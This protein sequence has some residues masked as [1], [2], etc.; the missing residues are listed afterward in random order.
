MRLWILPLLGLTVGAGIIAYQFAQP[1]LRHNLPPAATGGLLFFADTGPGS[2]ASQRVS[3]DVE[4]DLRRTGYTGISELRVV[5]SFPDP[6]VISR[7]YVVASGQYR[8]PASAPLDAYCSHGGLATRR[9]SAIAC[10]QDLGTGIGRNVEYHN[11]EHLGVIANN[12]D[13]IRRLLDFDGYLDGDN[14]IITGMVSPPVPASPYHAKMILWI[15]V[16]TPSVGHSGFDVLGRLAQIGLGNYGDFGSGAYIA[17]LSSQ[18]AGSKSDFA[19]TLYRHPV[20][21]MTVSS[22][23]Y[24]ASSLLGARHLEWAEPPTD[25]PN[26]LEWRSSPGGLPNVEFYANDPTGQGRAATGG[27][28]AGAMASLAAAGLLLLVQQMLGRAEDKRR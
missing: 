26:T 5:L 28:L 6:S 11:G 24:S 4:V 16:F 18:F 22:V 12:D 19:I 1:S 20:D 2:G 10:G 3:V 17:P 15:P 13:A 7:W 25:A 21:P 14:S 8:P 27:F 9:G 23:R